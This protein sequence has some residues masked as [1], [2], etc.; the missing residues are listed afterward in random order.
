MNHISNQYLRK[1]VAFGAISGGIVSG[2]EKIE[3]IDREPY[4]QLKYPIIERPMR[5][6][7]HFSRIAVCAGYGATIGGLTALTA[8]VSIPAYIYWYQKT[9]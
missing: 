2:M 4:Y 5:V 7:Y 1:W 6:V 9:D 8:P 3:N